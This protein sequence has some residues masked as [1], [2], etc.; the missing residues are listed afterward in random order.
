[1]VEYGNWNCTLAEARERALASGEREEGRG[2]RGN[3]KDRERGG[4]RTDR[5]AK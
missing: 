5:G 1:M 3:D 2:L 4:E